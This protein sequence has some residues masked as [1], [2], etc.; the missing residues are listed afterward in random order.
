MDGNGVLCADAAN[1]VYFSLSGDGTLLD[2]LGT[3]KG[4]RKLQAI[5]GRAIISVKTN[6]GKSAIG[7]QSA[8]IPTTFLNL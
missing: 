6:Y 2:N 8:G 1:W 3:S 7:V 5:N 4:S